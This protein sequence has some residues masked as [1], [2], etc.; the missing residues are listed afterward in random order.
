MAI[1]TGDGALTD[2]QLFRMVGSFK[3]PVTDIKSGTLSAIVDGVVTP[4]TLLD[5]GV[6]RFAS[7]PAS[8]AVISASFDYY[9]R[10]AFADDET[11]FDSQF[12][13]IGKSTIKMVTVR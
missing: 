12:L 4:V 13:N 8:G 6:V 7:A 3:L 5:G 9:W 2:F 11:E 1:G 10:V